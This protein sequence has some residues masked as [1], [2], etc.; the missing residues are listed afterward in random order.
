M[1]LFKDEFSIE[2]PFI[3]VFLCGH[4]YKSRNT[5]DKR[6][7]L[8]RFVEKNI[9]NCRAL[10]LEQNFTFRTDTKEYL[11]YDSAF[12]NSLSQIEELAAAYA[13]G[14]IIIHETISTA[15]ELGMFAINPML[16]KKICI[17]T[18]DDMSTDENKITFFIDNSFINNDFYETMVGKVIKFYPDIKVNKKSTEISE[19]YTQFHNDEIGENLG[20]EIIDFISCNRH[21]KINCKY[22]KKI[23]GKNSIDN[24]YVDYAINDSGILEINISINILK[25]HLLSMFLRDEYRR[26]LRSIKT[27]KAHINNV[28]YTRYADDLTIS[29]KDSEQIDPDEIK[30]NIICLASSLLSKYGLHLNNQKTRFYNLAVSNHVRITGVNIIRSDENK[31]RLTVGRSVKNKMF[32]DAINSLQEKDEKTINHIKGMQSFILSVEK[33]GYEDCF[34]SGMK[35]K[36]KSLGFDSL[37]SLIDSL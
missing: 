23:F 4:K 34:S 19:Y 9:D 1:F 16:S 33:K 30:E 15:A 5:S 20:R 3:S 11:A 37:K 13:D 2:N 32:W 7:I 22:K 12:L 10:I 24:S 36:L 25:I 29:F 14:I 26:E 21:N 17:I 6:A 8:K 35:E 18:P 31:R 27:I 28:I